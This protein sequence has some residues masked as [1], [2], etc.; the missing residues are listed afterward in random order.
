MSGHK[1]D[2]L[3]RYGLRGHGQVSFVLPVLI[4]NED[5]H[6]AF[7]DIVNSFFDRVKLHKHHPSYLHSAIRNG[8][9]YAHHHEREWFD[10]AHRFYHERAEWS[11]DPHSALNHANPCPFKNSRSTPPS[12]LPDKRRSTYL[13]II[14]DS[15]FTLSPGFLKPRVVS[16]AVCGLSL[17]H[18]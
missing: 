2:G 13:P 9:T 14:S 4:I 12:I 5:D 6:P 8:S 18:I 10:L 17:I 15:R 7:F 11:Y 16:R 1:I 3:G